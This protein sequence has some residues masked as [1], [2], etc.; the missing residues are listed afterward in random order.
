MGYYKI[1]VEYCDDLVTKED[2]EAREDPI[3]RDYGFIYAESYG[4]A[5]EYIDSTYG[6]DLISLR[7][8][9][10]EEGNIIVINEDNPLEPRAVY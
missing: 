10:L 7:L 6:R 9:E 5:A 2:V 8:E 4:A 1:A 3:K